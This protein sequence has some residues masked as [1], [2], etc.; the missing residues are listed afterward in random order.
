MIAFYSD[1]L[2]NRSSLT[3]SSENLLFPVSN[4]SHP[5]R[6]KVFR[7]QNSSCNIVLDFYE[8]SV[9]DSIL[10][11]DDPRQGLGVTTV[12]LELN[13]TNEWTAPAYT[14]AVPL[15]VVH[16]LGM[17]SFSDQ[18]YRFARIVMTSTDTFCELANIFIGKSI[19]F[20]NGMGIE[21]GWTYRDNDLSIIKENKNGQ[22]FVDLV[23]RQREFAFSLSV[24][25]ADEIDQVLEIYD[26]KG[27]GAPFFVR[28]GDDTIINDAD[29]FT[30]MVYFKSMPSIKNISFGL[31][32]MDMNLEE[33]M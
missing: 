5:F 22:K 6:S 26:S 7:S 29:R 10:I 15:N 17:A 18:S 33:A 28:I 20:Q 24:M 8:T 19:K 31:Y 12:T 2:V 27:I 13:G 16:G 23:G 9:I 30:S 11:V 32:D 25:N 3:A 1:N 21:L 4:L 14:I